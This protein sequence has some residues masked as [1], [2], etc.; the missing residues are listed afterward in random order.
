MLNEGLYNVEKS[1]TS[2]EPFIRTSKHKITNQQ[3]QN[4]LFIKK[5]QDVNRAMTICMDCSF[6]SCI[7][8]FIGSKSL[9]DLFTD[10]A[11][12]FYHCHYHC[13]L[14]LTFQQACAMQ[15]LHVLM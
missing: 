5:L 4:T 14:C 6:A 2:Y 15:S 13:H 9:I 8:L 10:V 11:L 7:N 12:V 3:E 1:L